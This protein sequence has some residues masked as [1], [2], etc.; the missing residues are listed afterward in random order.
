MFISIKEKLTLVK[1][2]DTNPTHS[3]IAQ[4]LL[5]CIEKGETPK[6]KACAEY[7][8]CSESVLTAFSKKYGYDGFKELAVRVKVETEYYDFGTIHKSGD[9]SK[10]DDYRN[11]IESSLQIIDQQDKE[12]E[13]LIELIKKS[14]KIGVLSCYQQYFNSELFVSELQ[15]LGYNAQ[16]NYQRK[17]NPSIFKEINDNDLFVIV[18]FG[19]DNQYLVN[20]YNLIKEKTDNIVVICS[21]SQKH[22]FDTYKEMIIVDYS[23]RTS[24]LD[25]TRSVLIMYLFSK[26]IYKL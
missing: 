5:D 4:Y 1:N 3:L 24:I 20:Y 25:S 23:E 15:L 9:T 16:I 11:I 26:I 22:K 2:N 8:F 21:R 13:S 18:G 19:L 14:N 7:A 10:K 17:S 12:I 6:S